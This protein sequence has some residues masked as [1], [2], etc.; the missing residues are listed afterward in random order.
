MAG[1]SADSNGEVE[2]GKTLTMTATAKEGFTFDY[3]GTVDESVE[4][5]AT[6]R[7]LKRAGEEGSNLQESQIN[8]YSTENPVVVPMNQ[9]RNMRAVFKAQTFTVTIVADEKQGTVNT[10]SAVYEY[11]EVLSLHAEPAEGY[12]FVGWSDGE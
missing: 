2:Y 4:S 6:A 12:D 9:S 8:R 5:A 11:G 10:P 3:W 7:A 1:G